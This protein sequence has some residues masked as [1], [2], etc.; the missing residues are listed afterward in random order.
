MEPFVKIALGFEIGGWK[1]ESMI[2][3]CVLQM[4]LGGGSSF[5]AG[6]PGKGMYT[7]LYREVLNGF[8]WAESAEAVIQIHDESGLFMIDGACPVDSIVPLIRTF[9][10]QFVRL[11]VQPVSE[12]ELN[13]AKNML[14]SMLMM[15]LE[16]RLVLCE[17]IGR[18]FATYGFR[19][20]PEESCRKI[21][22]V[23]AADLQRLAQRMV[24]SPPSIGAVGPD[25]SSVPSYE[26]IQKF[27]V[28]V[29]DEAFAK[30]KI[31]VMK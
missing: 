20:Q 3:A 31:E 22:L 10:E 30:Q 24:L 23:T 21:D 26:D 14:K 1:D 7:R 12:E 18:Q 8:Y 2:A 25:L 11:A 13:R 15:Q 29:R 27:V 16:S 17:D 5:S 9:T 28:Y 4:L 6:G 19:E